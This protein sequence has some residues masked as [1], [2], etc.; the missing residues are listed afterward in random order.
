MSIP[1][2]RTVPV[3]NPYR[4][5][6]NTVAQ[7][8]QMGPQSQ[9]RLTLQ[10]R[11]HQ[12]QSNKKRKTGQRTLLGEAA[13]E[14]N[15]DCVVCKGRLGGRNVHRA[16]HRLCPN[17]RRTKGITST[18]TLQQNKIDLAL[19][20]HFQTSPSTEEKASW[21]CTTKDAVVEFFGK[22][23]S[24]PEGKQPATPSPSKSMEV[25]VANALSAS[26]FCEKVTALAKDASFSNGCSN[27]R[28]PIAMLALAALVVDN[29][30]RMNKLEYFNGLTF[31]VPGT[32]EMHSS[33]PCHSIVGQELLLVDWV[34]LCGL[35]IRCPGC[36]EGILKE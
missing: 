8:R 22:R 24:A 20:K 11:T 3:V 21:R 17:N 9:R 23:A 35:D 4:R 29:V 34:K 33:P 7:R 15:K 14:A 10:E 18:A 19:K 6:G 2:V 13:F 31:T 5:Q 12:L 16:H 32:K 36:E 30:V 26:F 25:P 1:T 27:N 28:A